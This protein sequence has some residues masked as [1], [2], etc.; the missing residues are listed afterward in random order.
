MKLATDGRDADGDADQSK[1]VKDSD[2][3]ALSTKSADCP[4]RA[5]SRND[6]RMV[7]GILI[8][9]GSLRSR[10]ARRR[11]WGVITGSV[12][13]SRSWLFPGLL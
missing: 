10:S 3:D 12:A 8:W 9:P 2:D 13:R 1:T 4:A 5:Q 7:R 6:R 11:S